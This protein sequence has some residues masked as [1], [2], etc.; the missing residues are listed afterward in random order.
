MCQVSIFIKPFFR[1]GIIGEI[2]FREIFRSW[3]FDMA[4]VK[5]CACNSQCHKVGHRRCVKLR[6]FRIIYRKH[7]DV[8]DFTVGVDFNIRTGIGCLAIVDGI[9]LRLHGILDIFRSVTTPVYIK[10]CHF[11]TRQG[12]RCIHGIFCCRER[13]HHHGGFPNNHGF[14][15]FLHI[16]PFKFRKRRISHL[17][18]DRSEV[19]FEEP[20]TTVNAFH[21]H[22][23][24]QRR[25]IRLLPC[26][27]GADTVNN[28]ILRRKIHRRGFINDNNWFLRSIDIVCARQR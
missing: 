8:A 14:S 23:F 28:N 24:N 13:S 17:A 9:G 18:I 4:V 6:H 10:S 27:C 3:H 1:Q 20:C 11:R 2:N 12:N 5:A 15:G 21:I 7:P 19:F 25:A 22:T 16:H 26:E